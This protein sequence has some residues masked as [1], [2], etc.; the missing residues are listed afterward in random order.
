MK[1]AKIRTEH[2]WVLLVEA[3]QAEFKKIEGWPTIIHRKINDLLEPF[4]NVSWTVSDPASGHAIA[5][6]DDREMAINKALHRIRSVG[7]VK[8][9]KLV[10][11][12]GTKCAGR[13]SLERDAFPLIEKLK[14]VQSGRRKPPT[15]RRER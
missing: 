9:M 14:N 5:H 3:F 11:T 1:S 6:G 13:L 10:S 12:K 8:G 15:R 7:G 4:S 2:G